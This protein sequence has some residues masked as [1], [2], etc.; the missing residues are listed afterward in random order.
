MAFVN[1]L[2]SSGTIPES[3]GNLSALSYLNLGY[4]K[5]S[6][7][8][9]ESLGNLSALTDLCLDDNELS[10]SVPETLG[11]LFGVQ[12]LYLG[13][14]QL[15][16]FSKE[17]AIQLMSCMYFFCKGAAISHFFSL[18]PWVSPPTE[19]VSVGLEAIVRYYEAVELSGSSKSYRLKVV[20]VGEIFAGKT[21]LARSLLDGRPYLT[22][23]EDRT[24][25]VDVHSWKPNGEELLELMMWDFG[26][27][28]EYDSMRPFFLTM[29]AL[30]LLV[31]DL[32]KFYHE[33][34]DKGKLVC[35]WLDLL[36]C[37]VPGSSVLVVGTHID[38]MK[39]DDEVECAMKKLDLF[40]GKHLK[41]KRE[42]M[43]NI[44]SKRQKELGVDKI[45]EVQPP[46]D[47]YILGVMV[48]S[49]WSGG[50]RMDAI[51]KKIVELVMHGVRP[52]PDGTRLFP[53]V[54]KVIPMGWARSS[55]VMVALRDGLDPMMAALKPGE[56]SHAKV[57]GQ[58]ML[59]YLHLE[60]AVGKWK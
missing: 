49:C 58:T 23:L 45:K 51:R 55:A 19:V 36:L 3:L 27:H 14:N 30:N 13:R 31:V 50:E 2:F 4:N 7:S 53:T 38:C 56:V 39:G 59:P 20:L 57:E 32:Y 26:A 44:F 47:L 10:G 33:E 34:S 46:A 15:S 21:S 1:Q 8:I 40:I 35:S 28:K 54:G 24:R 52:G 18:N 60:D 43:E 22:T 37:K 41:V 48:V 29:G 11:N 12:E 5:F 25:G 16:V 6:G 17:A 42:E 9:P